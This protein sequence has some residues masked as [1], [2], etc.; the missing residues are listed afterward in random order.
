MDIW[1]LA[2]VIIFLFQSSIMRV[3][4]FGSPSISA[5][6]LKQLLETSFSEIVFV[7]SNPDKRIKR[8]KELK[9]TAVSQFLL[10]YHKKNQNAQMPFLFRPEDLKEEAF[11]STLKRLQADI[12]IIF[13]YGKILPSEIFEIPYKESNLKLGS[14]NLHAS[15]LPN[16]RGASPLQTVILKG[17]MKTGWSLQYITEK[18]DAGDVIDSKEIYI[19]PN[20]SCGELTGR[21]LPDGIKLVI[22]TLE[23]MNKGFPNLSA[24]PQN[25][26]EATYCKKIN[27]EAAHISWN[28]FAKDI[29][30][31][32]RAY[33]PEPIAWSFLEKKR[34]KIYRTA[35]L[36]T[37]MQLPN[38]WL[39]ASPGTF[40]P[41]PNADQKEIWVKTCDSILSI[42]ELQLENRKR[43]TAEEFL[44][45]Y[46][47]KEVIIL[48]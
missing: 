43:V 41:S 21:I 5:C 44:N 26:K 24:E 2:S 18:L 33:N 9:P 35:L 27:K 40:G 29:H 28:I 38:V 3:G 36:S 15:L 34:M 46:R 19:H 4:Y 45:G 11:I 42:L 13:A 6:L 30:N 7:V 12:F 20:E 39:K 31:L 16:W 23:K 37:G 1:T 48:N 8:S 22:K 17:E 14:I 10:D 32:I 25:E 47:Q